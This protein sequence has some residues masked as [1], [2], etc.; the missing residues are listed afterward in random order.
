MKGTEERCW[1][2]N[3]DWFVALLALFVFLLAAPSVEAAQ[4]SFNNIE[5]SLDTTVSYGASWRV[6]D[7]DPALIGIANGGEKTGVNGDDGNLNYDK[8]LVSNVVKIT[9]EL[10]LHMENFGLFVRGSAFYDFENMDGTRARTPLTDEAEDQ[11]G[12][13]VDLLDAFVW[14]NFNLG[15]IPV[16]L[17]VGEQVVS[18]GES[19]FIRN[20]INAINPVD[21]A[22]LRLPGAQL[23][24]GLIPEGMIWSSIGLTENL[25]LEGFY[26][27]DWGSTEIAPPG[28]YWSTND[29]AGDGGEIVMLG[30]G[31]LPEGTVPYSIPRAPTR[32][33]KDSG[34]FGLAARIFAPGLNDTEFGIFYM[35]YHSRTPLI[36]ALSATNPRPD[37]GRYLTE[38]PE[39]IQ[40]IG[41]SFATEVPFGGF[42]LQGEVSHRLDAPV[43]IDDVQILSKAL[44]QPS[45]ISGPFV[46]GG[47]VQGYT[48]LDVT[49]VQTTATKVFGP[50]LGAD[51]LTLVGEV[52]V[53]HVHG[54]PDQVTELTLEGPTGEGVDATS[55]GY[56]AKAKFTFFNAI[57]SVN[58]SPRVAWRHD[59][60]GNSPSTGGFRKDRRAIT[61]GLGFDYQRNLKVDVSYT[62]FFGADADNKINDRD[63]IAANIKY[64]F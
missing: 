36:S 42:S 32:E 1:S 10:D 47:Y 50:T 16:A 13:D 57:G 56:R 18:W 21:A 19:S 7:R 63:L 28:G 9:S 45:Q 23:K 17:R 58:V 43:Q 53:H 6:E 8:G 5:G 30:N 54:L 49:Q 60:D 38:Y 46:P 41:L 29:Y 11:V 12:R 4:F 20:G 33:A 52:A 35:N 40:L 15:S 24:E 22:A 62:N 31:M 2:V 64:S 39:D 26:L 27:Y 3:R 61:F 37:S 55:W 59:V 48:L 51:K 14:S 34:Q 44:G 25:T